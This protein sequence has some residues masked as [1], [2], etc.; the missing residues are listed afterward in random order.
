MTVI[1]KY[2]V[3]ATAT[4]GEFTEINKRFENMVKTTKRFNSGLV[5]TKTIKRANG[6]TVDFR[7][8]KTGVLKRSI[9]LL[10]DRN[11]WELSY[12]DYK[13]D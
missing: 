9:S 12:Q 13:E 6:T 8:K 7:H 3:I 1:D 4:H 10:S 11:G 5:S 2:G